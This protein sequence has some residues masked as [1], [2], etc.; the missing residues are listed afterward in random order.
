MTIKLTTWAWGGNDTQ[1][2]ATIEYDYPE[3]GGVMFE[4]NP[5]APV[6]Q[7]LNMTEQE[8]KDWIIARVA[9]ERANKEHTAVE[10][11]LNPIKNQELE[12]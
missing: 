9:S 8:I 4:I 3:N 1:L 7:V 11:L 12:P 5:S 2:I 6:S 10:T